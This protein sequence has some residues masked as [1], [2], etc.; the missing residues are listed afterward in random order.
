MSLEHK[1]NN[2]YEQKMSR[3]SADGTMTGYGLDD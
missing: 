3:E 1:N 2:E